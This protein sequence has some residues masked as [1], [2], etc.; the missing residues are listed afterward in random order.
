MQFKKIP[1][2]QNS[3]KH[4]L[5]SFQNDRL[6]H[7]HLFLGDDGSSSLA[8]AWAFAQYLLCTC[9]SKNDSCGECSSCLKSANLNHPDIHWVFPIVSSKGKNP[10]SDL[11]MLDWRNFLTQNNYPNEGQ[12]F[13]HL[14]AENKQ[15][16]IGI[17]DALSLNNKLVYKPFLGG[18]RV[19]IIWHS[20]KMLSSTA[21]KL[22]KLLKPVA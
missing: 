7:A 3:K 21:N 22:L 1:C 8:M 6:S 16:F 19:I 13:S 2:D 10:T 9:R 4:L 18:W 17:G 15:G 11:F 5:S 20:E 14:G 12:W